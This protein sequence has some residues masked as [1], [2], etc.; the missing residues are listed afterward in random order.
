MDRLKEGCTISVEENKGKARRYNEELLVVDP[1]AYEEYLHEDY[2]IYG[3][4]ARRW[5]VLVRGPE[6][7]KRLVLEDFDP[8]PT[9]RVVVE[10]VIGEGDKVAVRATFM[11]EGKPTA[12]AMIMYRF[13]DG[14]IIEDWTTPLRSSSSG[15]LAAR[16]PGRTVS[17]DLAAVR[18]WAADE[19]HHMNGVGG[20]AG[21]R[22][23][24]PT[25]GR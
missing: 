6:D 20:V 15:S 3:R 13:A 5:P 2:T 14:K 23:E 21:S 25:S 12:N 7:L 4:S 24:M 8:I 22:R 1:E 19:S 10:D 16:L 9:F 11:L 17:L 18:S